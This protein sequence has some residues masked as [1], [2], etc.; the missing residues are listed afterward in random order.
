MSNTPII[1]WYRQDL[2]TADQPALAAA[3]ASGRPV[4][5]VYILDDTTPGRWRMGGASRWWLH[6]SLLRLST[7]LSRL[8][9]PLVFRRGAYSQQL[10]A[11]ADEL[12][13]STIM[14]SRSYEPW[15]R[16][17]ERTIHDE[18]VARG[19]GLQRFAGP[20]LFEPDRVQTSTGGPYRVF[21]PYW[22]AVSR[23]DVRKPTPA[24][25]SLSSLTE[26]PPSE[27]LHEWHLQPRQPD[28][29]AGLRASWQPGEEG[30]NALLDTFLSGPITAY[31]QRRDTPANSKGTSRLSAHLHFGEIS[32]ATLWHAALAALPGD[33]EE[34]RGRDTFLKEIGWREFSY[35]LLF[36]QPDL[37]TKPFRA[38]F[39]AFPWRD[40]RL[41]YKAWTAGQTGYPIVD[42]G[43]REL[44]ATGTMHNRV[45]MIAA[46]FLV[47]HLL[48]PWQRGQE[49]FWDCLVDADLASNSASWQWV[50]GCGADA[51]PYFRIFNP[52]VQGQRYDTD[53]NYVRRWVPELSAMSN[54]FIHAPWLAPPTELEHA[55]IKLGHTYPLPIVDHADS[56]TRALAAY[57]QI[58]RS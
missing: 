51:A 31:H 28:W 48:I 41:A 50:A 14:C 11:L 43:M 40:D 46:S 19:G 54:K 32:P 23:I 42:A 52:I 10:L 2:R 39:T 12:Q 20:V 58:R 16:K 7:D 53:G 26:P 21:S 3:A 1:V 8:G 37:P 47:K 13:T 55:D 24:P 30:A 29:A 36:H 56:R 18:L 6:D 9:A 22:R 44:W 35:H 38:E 17:L 57:E 4:Q 27:N 25:T 33:G 15:A 45:R 49:W 5:P 34:V